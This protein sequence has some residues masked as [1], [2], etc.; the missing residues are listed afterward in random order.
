MPSHK[1]PEWL[2]EQYTTHN[3]SVDEIVEMSDDATNAYEVEFY[4]EM[5]G[6]AK[7]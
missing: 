2:L 5:Y 3:K 6:I 1:D 7:D 4:L